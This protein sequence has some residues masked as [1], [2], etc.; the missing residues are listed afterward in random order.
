MSTTV[1]DDVHASHSEGR[2]VLTCDENQSYVVTAET[3]AKDN[4]EA[5]HLIAQNRHFGDENGKGGA[6]N[7]AMK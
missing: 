7:S 1:D 6:S 4:V 2:M 3:A 5:K